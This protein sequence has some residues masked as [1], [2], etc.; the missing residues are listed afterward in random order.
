MG[1]KGSHKLGFGGINLLKFLELHLPSDVAG[2][3]FMAI[4]TSAPELFTNV[5][6]TFV[7]QGDLGIGTIVGSAVFNILAVSACCGLAAKET[8]H[9]EWWSL[10]RDCFFYSISV[11]MLLVVLENGKVFWYEALVLIAFYGI[12]I[13]GKFEPFNL[14]FH[15]MDFPCLTI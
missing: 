8:L 1:L 7:T 6:G 5:I 3:T 12:Y 10:T 14:S 9:L 11:I 13:L 4:A 15:K 2:A